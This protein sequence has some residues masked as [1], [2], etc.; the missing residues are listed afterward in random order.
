MFIFFNDSKPSWRQNKLRKVQPCSQ[1]FENV[2]AE[3][4]VRVCSISVSSYYIRW[5]LKYNN[6]T[7][8]TPNTN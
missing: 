1:F 7:V 4:T 5:I 6:N 3:S 2:Y 8:H